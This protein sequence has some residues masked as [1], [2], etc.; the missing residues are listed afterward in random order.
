M[1]DINDIT[2]ETY[3]SKTFV[4]EDGT[5]FE[6]TLYFIPLQYM[7]VI[8]ELIY[9]GFTIKNHRVVNSPNFLHQ[10]KNKIPFGIGCISEGDREPM[11]IGDFS[12]GASKLILLTESEVDEYGDFLS[13]G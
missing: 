10:F 8:T 4:L 9:D 11:F 12:S 2:N 3:Q 1:F 7:W 6:M 5:S 13:N